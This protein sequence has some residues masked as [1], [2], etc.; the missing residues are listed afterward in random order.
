MTNI[1]VTL[2]SK[3]GS[4]EFILTPQEQLVLESLANARNGMKTGFPEG[5]FADKTLYGIFQKFKELELLVEY[6][7]RFYLPPQA[8][9]LAQT[10]N[11]N[12][13]VDGIAF[14]KNFN[15]IGNHSQIDYVNFY[16]SD[17]YYAIFKEYFSDQFNAEAESIY[18][19]R[20]GYES[21]QFTDRR[22]LNEAFIP[23]F[24]EEMN[25]LNAGVRFEVIN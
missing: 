25:K 2:N 11:V 16:Q 3:R 22:T 7:N 19:Q 10:F 13:G 6:E 23:I 12:M 15:Q 9:L 21:L 24:Q 1:K 18:K 8:Y 17:Y 14:I 20:E 4:K 5:H